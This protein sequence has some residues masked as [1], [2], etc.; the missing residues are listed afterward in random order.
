MVCHLFMATYQVSPFLRQL[1]SMTSFSL[2]PP[3][4][5]RTAS[6]RSWENLPSGKRKDVMMTYYLNQF[7]MSVSLVS[8]PTTTAA[9]TTKN[10]TY[11]FRSP[12]N[13]LPSILVRDS[14]SNLKSSRPLLYSF[15]GRFLVS[16]SQHDNVSPCKIIVFVQFGEVTGRKLGYI[17]RFQIR[18]G[19][20]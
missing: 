3:K 10:S 18:R 1:R 20:C 19:S 7:P 4:A 14:S 15:F 13:P 2:S 11:P 17:V 8:T 5:C 9:I 12:F 6:S 16:R